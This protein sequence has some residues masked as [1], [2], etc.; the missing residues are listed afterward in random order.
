[1]ASQVE[2]KKKKKEPNEIVVVKNNSDYIRMKLNRLMKN[3]VSLT[4]FNL[5]LCLFFWFLTCHV[6]IF[7]NFLTTR[8]SLYK[9]Q[10]DIMKRK[11]QTKHLILLGILSKTISPHL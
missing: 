3:P 7:L 2:S 4:I 8:K 9:Y 1:M 11:M 6:N 5:F 10:K